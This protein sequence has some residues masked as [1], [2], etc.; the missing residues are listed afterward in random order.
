LSVKLASLSS[1]YLG[2]SRVVHNSRYGTR[3]TG[4]QKVNTRNAEAKSFRDE[5]DTNRAGLEN[6]VVASGL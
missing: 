4:K 6:L 3:I 1:S 2:T 5:I